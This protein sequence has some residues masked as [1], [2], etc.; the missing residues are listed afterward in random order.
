MTSEN[1]LAISGG[2]PVR[3]SYLPYGRQSLDEEDIQSVVDILRGDYLTTGPTI[4]LF[5][6]KVAEYAGSSYAVAFS[7]GT[8]A[9]HAACFAA[10]ISQETKSLLHPSHLRQ[11]PIVFCT[12]APNRFSQ[13]L[14]RSHTILILILSKS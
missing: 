1:K 13:I 14:T 9:L 4:A 12:W 10:G 3:D 2:K 8:A 5:E 6:E 11:V 7:S